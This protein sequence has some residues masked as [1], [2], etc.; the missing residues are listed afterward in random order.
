MA[1]EEPTPEATQSAFYRLPIPHRRFINELIA[2]GFNAAEA[3]RRCGYT[4]T[5][6]ARQQGY[7]MSTNVDIKAGLRAR[8]EEIE[9]DKR[10][11]KGRLEAKLD[12]DSGDFL[13]IGDDGHVE[14]DLKKARDAG[15][16]HLIKK[17]KFKKGQ[18][19]SIELVDPLKV[20][21]LLGRAQGLFRDRVEV[22]GDLE[23]KTGVIEVPAALGSEAWED[24]AKDNE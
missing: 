5:E 15:K 8:L 17:L 2:C 12:V 14:L 24:A 6:H 13:E 16:L 4:Q 7:R 20:A 19:E 23:Q 9:L 1:D 22:S 11:L 18:L 3:A 21:E 10:E